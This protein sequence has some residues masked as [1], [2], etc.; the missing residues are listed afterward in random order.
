MAERGS[1]QSFAFAAGESFQLTFDVD[2]VI[3]GMTVR[4]SAKRTPASTAVLSTSGS[5]AV[6]SIPS[7]QQCKI[8]VADE[9]TSSLL[10]T[11]RYSVEIEDGAGDKSE[12]AHGYLTFSPKMT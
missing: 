11:Y 9:N 3:T 4:F 12:V 7:A 5:T 8:T 10:G 6:A 1:P 2:D